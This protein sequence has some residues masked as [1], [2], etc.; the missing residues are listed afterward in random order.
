[1]QHARP[2]R[3]LHD[4]GLLVSPFSTPICDVFRPASIGLRFA[5]TPAPTARQ[6]AAHLSLSTGA[7]VNLQIWIP[8]MIL[9]GIV[10]FS[11]LYGFI[12]VCDWV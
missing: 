10:G 2:V 12:A 1:M 7:S 3:N 11:L 4:L 5:F 9:L 6:F 8:I